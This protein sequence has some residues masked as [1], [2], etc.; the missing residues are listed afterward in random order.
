MRHATLLAVALAVAACDSYGSSAPAPAD[1]IITFG[2]TSYSPAQ[3]MVTAGSKVIF[4]G[5]FSAHPLHPES[6]SISC[7]EDTANTP[8]TAKTSGTDDLEV[9]FPNAG[10]FPFYCQVHC[11]IAG[12]RGMITVT[13]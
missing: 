10:T 2:G 5:N 7:T 8:I 6:K 4:R 1:N 12:M 11:S 3:L 9:T 13:P